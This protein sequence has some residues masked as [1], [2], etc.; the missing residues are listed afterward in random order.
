MTRDRHEEV[1]EV[2][3]GGQD[4]PINP[5]LQEALGSFES[6]KKNSVKLAD[7]TV[8]DKATGDVFTTTDSNAADLAKANPAG[9]TVAHIEG[10]PWN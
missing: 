7:A 3:Q 8:T 1:K 5:F 4:T 6:S 10:T 2:G 9:L